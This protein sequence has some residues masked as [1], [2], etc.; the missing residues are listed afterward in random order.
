MLQLLESDIE[1]LKQHR[2]FTSLVRLM[3]TLFMSI[4]GGISWVEVV[5]PTID[6]HP[7][8][9]PLFTMY[10]AFAVFCVL[11]IITGVFVEQSTRM[12]QEDDEH[13]MIEEIEFR[14]KWTKTIETLFASVDADKSGVISYPE[15]CEAMCDMRIETALRNCG[16]DLRKFSLKHVWELLDFDNS[17]TIEIHEFV[18]GV[19]ELHGVAKS[20]D[21]SRLR[22]EL[23]KAHIKLNRLAATENTLKDQIVTSQEKI[24]YL[25][26]IT[27]QLSMPMSS[28]GPSIPSPHPETYSTMSSLN[29][30]PGHTAT[31][32]LMPPDA[33]AHV[34]PHVVDINE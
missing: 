11:N 31:S 22:H 24:D 19:Q 28:E 27:S 4:S 25:C 6:V 33:S 17:G 26:E 2:H 5:D 30:C 29:S 8:I 3:F 23:R 12:A 13:M 21:I 1:Q 7:L 14:K 10:I 15:F 34:L 18:T 32:S 16:V 20:L 9:A